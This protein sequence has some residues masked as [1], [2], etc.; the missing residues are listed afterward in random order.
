MSE[1]D[2]QTPESGS[3]VRRRGFPPDLPPGDS[4]IDGLVLERQYGCGYFPGREIT[5]GTGLYQTNRCVNCVT[6]TRG[7]SSA[8]LDGGGGTI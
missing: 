1:V 3:R 6:V 2:T 4:V 5:R 7:V 8:G